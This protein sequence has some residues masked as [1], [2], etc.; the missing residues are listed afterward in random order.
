[1]LAVL[2]IGSLPHPA[3]GQPTAAPL[4]QAPVPVVESDSDPTRPVFISLRPEFYRIAD[5]LEQRALIVRYDA[6]V[7]PTTRVG[8]GVPGVVLRF[9][10][11]FTA[12]DRDGARAV[13]VG[14]T[15]GQFFVMPYARGSFIWAIGSGFIVP[16]ATDE[17]VG[18]GKWVI[19]PVTAPIWRFPGGLFLVKFQNLTSYAGDDER[20]D[21]NH[22]LITPT[23]IHVVGREWWILAD[24]ETK[25]RWAADGRTGVKSG[26]QIGR[27]LGP[28]VGLW[29]KPELWWGPNRDG[30]W[31]L[32]LGIVW[33][34]RRQTKN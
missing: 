26:L 10:V 5:A 4:A 19:A 3:Q 15:Y 11:P 25:T 21:V 30:E 16:T 28:G 31:N 9:E 8:R 20:P 18:G 23:F 29:V 14:D 17:S 32:K 22:L 2:A 27:R 34:E 24:T 33:Y 13:G 12:A 6:R 7:L 1:M